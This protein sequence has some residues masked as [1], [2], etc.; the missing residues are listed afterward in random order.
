MAKWYPLQGS[1]ESVPLTGRVEGQKLKD[2]LSLERKHILEKN[3][4][5]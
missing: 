5:V 2:T 1:S 3:K 4:V